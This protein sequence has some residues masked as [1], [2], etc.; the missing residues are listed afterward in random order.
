MTKK[1]V[2]PSAFTG[3][4]DNQSSQVDSSPPRNLFTLEVGEELDARIVG[5]TL[6]LSKAV[7]NGKP[8]AIIEWIEINNP[9]AKPIKGTLRLSLGQ[10]G[11][12]PSW[13]R[14][15]SEV[16]S[17]EGRDELWGFDK[18]PNNE[19]G[20][21]T[22]LLIEMFGDTQDENLAEDARPCVV[23]FGGS[24]N[25]LFAN[26][27]LNAEDAKFFRTFDPRDLYRRE[28]TITLTNRGLLTDDN[29]WLDFDIRK[30]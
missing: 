15:T 10:D 2:Q 17:P 25:I 20:I 29:E 30:A 14:D 13:K 18:R 21:F 5:A 19:L 9:D 11:S 22:R 24:Y 28:V 12:Q 16:S 1:P 26:E 6:D 3:T 8:T 7:F 4:L 23:F 27:T